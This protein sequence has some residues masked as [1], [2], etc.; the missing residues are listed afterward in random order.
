MVC[1]GFA[2]GNLAQVRRDKN[3]GVFV[4]AYDFAAE[5]S[6]AGNV[7]ADVG[8]EVGFDCA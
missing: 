5:L 2:L 4:D 7:I 8:K 6:K 1:D 3:V